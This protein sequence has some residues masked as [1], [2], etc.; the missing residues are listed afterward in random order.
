M[1]KTSD[2]AGK[3]SDLTNQFAALKPLIPL[4]KKLDG[5]P[6]KVTALQASA[7][8]QNEQLR[9]LG[10]AVSRLEQRLRDGKQPSD[11]DTS[12]EAPNL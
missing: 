5:I 12:P 10:L 11:Q 3:L 7:F 2:L 8:E 1:G 6:E 9:A 4:A